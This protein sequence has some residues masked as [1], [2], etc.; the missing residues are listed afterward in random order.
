MS[1]RF[2][3]SVEIMLPASASISASVACRQPVP[4]N[5]LHK[6]NPGRGLLWLALLLVLVAAM[7]YGAARASTESPGVPDVYSV[8]PAKPDRRGT[9]QQPLV[10]T[11]A[12][13]ERSRDDLDES[14]HARNERVMM[15]AT[16]VLAVFTAF[17]WAANIWLII[18]TRRVSAKQSID[19]QRAIGEQTR[20]ADAMQSVAEATRANALI[21]QTL[22]QK[23]MRAYLSVEFGSA[24]YQDA[25]NIF[26]AVP[27]MT[28]NGLTPARNVCFK[29]LADIL[30]GS[31][32]DVIEFADIGELIVNDIGIAP[33]QSFTFRGL[34]NRRVPD[35][36]VEGIMQGSTKRLFAWGRVTYDDV[37]GSCWETNFCFSYTFPKV[38]PDVKIGGT[39]F[40]KHNKAT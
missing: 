13:E 19:T 20:S 5:V 24:T 4:D 28:N 30:D 36:D 32:P 12:V 17:L 26:M 14:A 37:Y 6:G 3:R 27:M 16:V 21:V 15:N 1:F 25:N 35:A 38:G 18:E 22:L 40:P 31:K 8:P 2:R 39:Y 7:A 34:I 9:E 11:K 23:Q 33:R 29:V 10:I